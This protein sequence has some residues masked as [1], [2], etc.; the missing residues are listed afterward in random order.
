MAGDNKSLARFILDGILPA[1]R[2]VPQVE[3]E[4]NIDANGIVTVAARDQATGKEQHITIQPSSGLSDEEVEGL[5]R[6]A[7]EHADEDREK[8]QTAE[9]RNTADTL[10][11][12]AERTLN[13][14]EDKIDGDLKSRVEAAIK[15]VREAL[16]GDDA[17]TITSTTDELSQVM[18]EIGQ[19]VYAASGADEGGPDGAEDG[20]AEPEPES[21]DEGEDEGETA[22]TVEGEFR[23]V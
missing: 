3:V 19:A 7:E 15:S 14:N 11:Y 5:Q 20:G 8:R 13:D 2:G 23:E 21:E 6:E 12:T 18:Q 1:P 16:E 4:F 22:G 17:G 9:L 10:A